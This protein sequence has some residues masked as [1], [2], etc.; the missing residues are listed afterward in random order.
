MMAKW[1][2]AHGD[3]KPGTQIVERDWL[4]Q[5]SL[6]SQQGTGDTLLSSSTSGVML[7]YDT[8]LIIIRDAIN[9]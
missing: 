3:S 1:P 8:V 6:F 2:Q 5:T 9:V 4:S 7:S